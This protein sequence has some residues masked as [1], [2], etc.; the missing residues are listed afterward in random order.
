MYPKS[1]QLISGAENNRRTNTM[2]RTVRIKVYKFSELSK[3]AKQKAIQWGYDLNVD[4]DWSELSIEGHEERLK[5]KGYLNPK[6]MFSGFA[7]QGDG[8]CFTCSD[9]DFRLFL[10]G[11]YKDMEISASISHNSHHYYATSTTVNLNI[12]GDGLGDDDFSE[13]EQVI[14]D[15]REKLGNEIYSSLEK[16]YEW[17]TNEEQIIETIEANEYEFTQDGKRF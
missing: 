5:E 2:A 7:S 10:D 13:I 15:E 1:I 16:E 3:T 17:R 8:A 6:V 14:K 4:Y 12:E 11:K 9:I